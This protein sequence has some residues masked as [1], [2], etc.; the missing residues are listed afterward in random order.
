[1]RLDN[2]YRTCCA[3]YNLLH[4]YDGFTAG[5]RWGRTLAHARRVASDIIDPVASRHTTN[6]ELHDEYMAERLTDFQAAT[7][8]AQYRAQAGRCAARTQ[9]AMDVISRDFDAS[10]CGFMPINRDD[11]LTDLEECVAG[12]GEL[13][14]K[15]VAHYTH[16]RAKEKLWWLF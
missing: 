14:R 2:Q 11:A 12:W 16:A 9:F 4:A 5:V 1:M 10:G 8:R 6:D 15:L 7:L 3:L 13:R